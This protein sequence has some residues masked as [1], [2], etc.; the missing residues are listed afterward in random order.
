MQAQEEEVPIPLEELYSSNTDYVAI[1]KTMGIIQSTSAIISFLSSSILIWILKRS[2]ARF[3]S[4][5]HR[6]LLGMSV[7][8]LLFSLSYVTFMTRIT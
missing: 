2:N 1:T 5:Y 4:I 7:G 3:T 6:M 8:D